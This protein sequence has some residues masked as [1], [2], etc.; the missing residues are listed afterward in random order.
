MHLGNWEKLS[1]VSHR[2]KS[3]WRIQEKVLLAVV[4]R[5][6]KWQLKMQSQ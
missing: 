4:W 6:A 5:I 2:A 1:L 3:V